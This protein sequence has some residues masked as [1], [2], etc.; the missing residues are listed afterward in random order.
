MGNSIERYQPPRAKPLAV[1]EQPLAR[2]TPAL[3]FG[4]RL[5]ERRDN[6]CWFAHSA[7]MLPF[8]TEHRRKYIRDFWPADRAY[9]I[10]GRKVQESL[11]RKSAAAM[12]AAMLGGFGAKTDKDVLIAMLDMIEGD[13]IAIASGLWQPLHLSPAGLALACR[14]LI[15]TAKFVPKPAELH[16]ACREAQN[17]LHWAHDAADKLVDFVRRCDAVLLQ[18]DHDEW[19]KPYLTPKDQP[20]LQRMLDLHDIYGDGSDAF[21]EG[22]CDDDGNLRHPFAAL[23][24]AE[25][26]KLPGPEEASE[27]Q[28]PKRLAAAR[29]RSET[30]R[31]RKP[32]ANV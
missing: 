9:L 5:V 26:A 27:E 6:Y 31:S 12:I 30:K 15:A 24:E 22:D 18:F 2:I 32:R 8:V 29:K 20:V 4:T 16:A 1:F 28:Q 25:K 14:Q 3:N 13:E 23:L 21:D 10:L 7:R 11:D 19:E 17:R